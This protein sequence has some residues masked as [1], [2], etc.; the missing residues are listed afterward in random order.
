MRIL[1]LT[2]GQLTPSSRFRVQQFVPHFEQAGI[3]CQVIAGYGSHY[4]R[5]APK[6]WAPAY[7]L[8]AR[9]RRLIGGALASRADILFVQRPILPFTP[10][11][12]QLL[13][14]RGMP[15]VFDV[16]DAIFVAPNS[17]NSPSRWHTFRT[18]VDLSTRYFAG[19]SFLAE[20]GGAPEKTHVM[21]TVIDTDIYCPAP[22]TASDERV[23]IG[24]IGSATTVRFLD[25]ILPALRAVRT[26][27]P[28]VVIRIVSSHMP[29][30]LAAEDG[31]EFQ[32]W[33]KET[34]LTSLRTFDIGLMPME[35]NR[36]S[37]GKCGFKMIQYMAMGTPV[38]ADPFG[39][40]REIFGSSGAG[41]L[42]NTQEEWVHAM[43]ELIEDEALR[44]RQG[45]AARQHAVDHYSIRAVLPRYLD[46]FRAI[47]R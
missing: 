37:L 46:A 40:N 8:A 13:A 45:E 41:F 30:K 25:Q 17:E 39:A 38:V 4:N 22:R 43:S 21:P 11:P 42:A 33:S 5:I 16:D 15:I 18:C 35:Q 10:A 14:K 19:N 27:Y 34:E 9:S 32:A 6:P 2:E 23:V 20:Q 44:K 3:Q 7:K 47:A 36:V 26:C 28:Q 29:P 31:F 1:F 12:E 24:W